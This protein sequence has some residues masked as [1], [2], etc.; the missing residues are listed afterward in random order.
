MSINNCITSLLQIKDVRITNILEEDTQ[1]LVEVM[2]P[3]KEH[4]CPNCGSLTNRT[5][6]YRLQKINHGLCYK[7]PIYIMFKKRRYVCS[8]C[9]KRFYEQ[10][11]IVAK[12]QRISNRVNQMIIFELSN[13]QSMKGIGI[14]NNCSASTV[15]RKSKFL[16]YGKPSLP[17]TF[18][19]DEFKGNA[20]ARFQ[21]IITDVVRMKTL[22]ILKNRKTE[23]LVEYFMEYPL[24]ERSK[25][26]F[27]VMDM[28]SLFRSVIKMCFPNAQIIVDKFHFVRQVLTS[29]DEI[30]KQEQRNFGQDKR[31]YFKKS[32]SVLAKNYSDLSPDERL[33]LH[34]MLNQSRVLRQ[35]YALK[36]FLLRALK[37][38]DPE[39]RKMRLYRWEQYVCRVNI[40]RFK[41][42]MG[43]LRNWRKGILLALETNYTN[44]YT[45]GCNNRAKVLK[46]I[47]YGL[48]HFDRFRNRLLFIA[49]AKNVV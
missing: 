34:A 27:V 5:H 12:Y 23:D 7:K 43:T 48:R 36:E 29:L 40:P 35:A 1:I 3:T 22:D 42:L 49:N 18:G 10:N 11:T 2:L 21:C 17:E 25:V 37:H 28:C 41:T 13:L 4:A 9:K 44:G 19:I 8:V 16:S 6:D 26:K 15:M 38:P 32:R 31:K 30:R 46:R 47:S 45:E 33:Q 24:E 39:Q 20:G 14:L